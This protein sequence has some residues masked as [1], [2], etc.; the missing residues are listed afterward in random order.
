MDVAPRSAFLAAVILPNERTAVMGMINVV[1]TFSSSVGPQI[2]GL[3]A[4]RN[5]FWISFVTAGALKATYDLGVL[6]VFANHVSR[7]DKAKAASEA[8][9]AA[10]S[11]DG[12]AEGH[13]AIPT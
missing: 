1:K 7:E 5:L 3:L 13:S 11:A 2:T 10:R 6:A 4:G 12:N 8:D 9:A